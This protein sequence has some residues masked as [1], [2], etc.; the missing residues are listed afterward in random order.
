MRC[1]YFC[2]ASCAASPPT[3]WTVYEIPFIKHENKKQ[4]VHFMTRCVSN[5][6]VL[7]DTVRRLYIYLMN[8]A[9]YLDV[10]LFSV[11]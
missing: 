10:C 8:V 11:V 1:L 5:E 2:F 6:R 3:S 4:G 7:Y 9:W